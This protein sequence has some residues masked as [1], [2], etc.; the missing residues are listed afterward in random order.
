ELALLAR[1]LVVQMREAVAVDLDVAPI[2]FERQPGSR[3]LA[4]HGNGGRVE[5]EPFAHEETRQSLEKSVIPSQVVGPEEYFHRLFPLKTVIAEKPRSD[6]GLRGRQ[7]PESGPGTTLRVRRTNVKWLF[8]A[9]N[10]RLINHRV[11]V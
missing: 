9:E 6:P 2:G 10:G 8:L 7:A 11:S 4:R 3:L 5:L 1:G